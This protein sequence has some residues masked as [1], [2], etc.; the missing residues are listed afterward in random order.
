MQKF[1]GRVVREVT[2]TQKRETKRKY[3]LYNKKNQSD[4]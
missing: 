1:A 4:F 3:K 2:K